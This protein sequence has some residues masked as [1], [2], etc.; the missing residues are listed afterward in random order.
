MISELRLEVEDRDNLFGSVLE[1]AGGGVLPLIQLTGRPSWV[2]ALLYG[3]QS[4]MNRFV[5]NR[6][7]KL[8]WRA[9]LKVF[10]SCRRLNATF[11]RNC[12]SLRP[13]S[14]ISY[15]VPVH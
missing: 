6:A 11:Q 8:G 4:F 5:V 15:V 1:T 2:F 9:S 10:D 7:Q 12:N 14:T 13:I 3:M